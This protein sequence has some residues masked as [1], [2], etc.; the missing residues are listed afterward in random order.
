MCTNFVTI[1]C[2]WET[3]VAY[4][5]QVVFEKVEKHSDKTCE[6]KEISV[7][8]SWSHYRQTK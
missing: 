3:I 5:F 8:K 2:V 7:K 4:A 1:F 6:K